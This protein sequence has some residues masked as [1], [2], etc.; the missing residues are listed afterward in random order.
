[1]TKKRKLKN[2][3]ELRKEREQKAEDRMTN[4]HRPELRCEACGCWLRSGNHG[5]YCSPCN[6]KRDRGA[7]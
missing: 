4:P 5:P 6:S 3:S 1:M 2:Q 7:A